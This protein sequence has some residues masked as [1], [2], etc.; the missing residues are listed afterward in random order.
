MAAIA[1]HAYNHAP[2][3]DKDAVMKSNSIISSL[4]LFLLLVLGDASY[5]DD[6]RGRITY[7]R[8]AVTAIDDTGVPRILRADSRI[9]LGEIVETGPNS[10]LISPKAG[11]MT[12]ALL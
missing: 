12:M 6:N 7:L 2:N 10:V 4:L 8:G 11:Q 9:R 1:N 5:A 3:Y